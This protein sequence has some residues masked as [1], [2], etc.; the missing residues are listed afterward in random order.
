MSFDPFI[1]LINTMNVFEISELFHQIAKYC[2]F[3]MVKN[4]MKTCKLLLNYRFTFRYHDVIK[5]TDTGS[6]FL[7]C[8]THISY[9]MFGTMLIPDH[10]QHI[11]LDPDV[12][13]RN[14]IPNIPSITKTL[15]LNVWPHFPYLRQKYE[16]NLTDLIDQ[17]SHIEEV[18]IQCET[19]VN[20]DKF[21]FSFEHVKKMTA[22]CDL[23]FVPPSIRYLQCKYLP[24]SMHLEPQLYTSLEELHLDYLQDEFDLRPLFNLKKLTIKR[25]YIQFKL[26]DSVHYLSMGTIH[27]NNMH[28]LELNHITH[29]HVQGTRRYTTFLSHLIF[30]DIRSKIINFA[31]P[32]TLKRLTL[33]NVKN[34]VQPLKLPRLERLKVSAR[35][36]Y[37]NDHAIDLQL[38]PQLKIMSCKR[39][40]E[41]LHAEYSNVLKLKLDTFRATNF[42]LPSRL[43]CLY[44]R[45]WF[46]GCI[47]L[48][49]SVSRFNCENTIN[50]DQI[51]CL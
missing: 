11:T 30:L 3:A 49:R 38:L 12:L 20:E 17:H 2:D 48:P 43:Q 35:R 13:F 37:V 31:L 7:P 28:V 46:G 42:V 44:I 40:N 16:E 33:R 26:P 36:F 34:I 15:T 29:L 6:L 18:N 41:L 27:P 25:S 8:C 9:T 45:D 10:L 14:Y 22:N 4:L 1:G 51:V 50:E 32:S 47:R 23:T 21:C 39:P 24:Q 19:L 5:N